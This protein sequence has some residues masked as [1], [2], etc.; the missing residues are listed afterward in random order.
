MGVT[1][2]QEVSS[3]ISTAVGTGTSEEPTTS[4][5]CPCKQ[6][7]NGTRWRTYSSTEKCITASARKMSLALER[8]STTSRK[9]EIGSPAE[10]CFLTSRELRGSLR[11]NQDT[12]LPRKICATPKR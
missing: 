10:G 7:R 4:S 6:A 1:L 3:V 8:A 11:S 12:Q 5:S 9:H 2:P